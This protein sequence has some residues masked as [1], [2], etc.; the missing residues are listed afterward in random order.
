MTYL[1]YDD[2]HR[3]HG[4]RSGCPAPSLAQNVSQQVHAGWRITITE[5]IVGLTI[6]RR[7]YFAVLHRPRD[8]ME[9]VLSGFPSV[10]AAREAADRWIETSETLARLARL[11]RTRQ[12]QTRLSQ[13][14]RRDETT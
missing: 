5:R 2:D 10:H 9:H 7:L 1:R 6:R 11:R 4:P 3:K 13:H 12:R 8:G 14:A